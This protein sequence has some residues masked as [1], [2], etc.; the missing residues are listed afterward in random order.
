M[1]E[2]RL[3]LKKVIGVVDM[4]TLRTLQVQID[5]LLLWLSK[6]LDIVSSGVNMVQIPFIVC[7]YCN[8]PHSTEVLRNV[9]NAQKYLI[10]HYFMHIK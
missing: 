1:Y 9:I 5:D 10:Y 6:K 8:V 4:D 7:E 3:T 2:D